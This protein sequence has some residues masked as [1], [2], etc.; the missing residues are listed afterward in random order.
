VNPRVDCDG[1]PHK[2]LNYMAAG[3]PIVSFAGSA[4]TI[5]HEETGWIVEGDDV[6][7][8][9]R[10]IVHL[11]ASPALAARLGRNA[12]EKGQVEYSWEDAARRI[13]VVYDRLIETGH[14]GAHR[15]D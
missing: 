8:F 3:L 9:A 15:A 2:L 1:V 14:H 5:Q 11:L 6:P 7:A 12:R 10:A 4:K 13:R